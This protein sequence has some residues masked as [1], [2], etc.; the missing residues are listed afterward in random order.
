MINFDDPGFPWA[1]LAI[2]LGLR[3]ASFVIERLAAA[4]AAPPAA[5]DDLAVAPDDPA[6]RE[7]APSPPG[8]PDAAADA[9]PAGP[10]APAMAERFA[11]PRD[12][13]EVAEVPR[14]VDETLLAEDAEPASAVP[15]ESAPDQADAP[16]D[17][18]GEDGS[19]GEFRLWHELL[20]SAIIAVVLVFFLIRPF[21]LQ[22]FYI[23]T[24]SMIPTLQI[25]DKVLATKFTYRLRE[26][27][28]GDVV[29]FHAPRK[30]LELNG[31]RY[32]PKQ[33]T[34]Y[35]KRVVGTP[36]DRV[37]ITY[38]GVY[39]NDTL[40][41]EPYVAARP[42]YEFP[43]TVMGDFSPRL[44]AGVAN[45]LHPYINDHA[46]VVPEGYLLVLG[47]NR[48]ESHDGHV[49]GLLERDAVVGKAVVIFLP[50]KRIGFIR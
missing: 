12:P 36:G 37:R 24:G 16:A 3:L 45:A 9:V 41:H 33:P 34:D 28:V 44:G 10:P 25:G 6:E 11:P 20:D 46:L 13:A 35:V 22:A 26:P 40:L 4:P 1:L 39:V 19:R 18:R 21:L 17:A 14:H 15:A 49:W 2:L 32:N 29:V 31:Q 7:E 23:P 48:R 30:A 5:G 47:D 43:L 42:D 27:R 8:A 50:L 38:D